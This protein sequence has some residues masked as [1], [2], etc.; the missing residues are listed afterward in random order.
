MTTPIV[1]TY[2]GKTNILKCHKKNK[3]MQHEICE[4]DDENIIKTYDNLNNATNNN[5]FIHYWHEKIQLTKKNEN[6]L[7]SPNG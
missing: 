7:L 5:N 1:K 3:H 4:I 2:I 6:T